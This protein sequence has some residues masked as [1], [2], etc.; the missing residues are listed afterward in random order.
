MPVR[1]FGLCHHPSR[2]SLLAIVALL[3]LPRFAHAQSEIPQPLAPF[4][5]L[6]GAWKGVGIPAANKLKGWPERHVWSWAFEQ[7][8][9]VALAIELTGSKLITKGR[10]TY[11]AKSSTYRL[12][13]IDPAGKPARFEGALDDPGQ[14][15]TLKRD[16]PLPDG[17]LQRIT[18]RLNKNKIRYVVWDDQKAGGAPRHVRIIESQL[19][20]EGESFAAGSTSGN[21]PKCI[22][23]GGAATLTVSYQG[24][25][26]P[27]CCTGCRDEF[28][29]DP[30][31]YVAKLAARAKDEPPAAKPGRPANDD[32]GFDALLEGSS[33]KKAES[34]DREPKTDTPPPADNK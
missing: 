29:A 21:A 22:L 24:K 15:L 32:T 17:T 16:K 7:G 1:P 23:T 26:Y 33:T 8:K 6:I 34:K 5:H 9:P 14:V 28:E 13:G 27:V 3:A 2:G 4:E 11:D 20:K 10:L 31:K 25:S 19:G 30:D 18:L 12:E